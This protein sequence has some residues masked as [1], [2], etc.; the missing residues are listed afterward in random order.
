MP[1]EVGDGEQAAADPDAHAPSAGNQ[2]RQVVVRAEPADDHGAQVAEQVV[3]GD[4]PRHPGD[5]SEGEQ[6]HEG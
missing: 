5:E 1:V 2:V 6:Q 3:V 4:Q